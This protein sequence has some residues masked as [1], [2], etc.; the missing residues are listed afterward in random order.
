MLLW[1]TA[2]S[3]WPR[4]AEC[5]AQSKGGSEEM[6]DERIKKK[7]CKFFFSIRQWGRKL[8]PELHNLKSRTSSRRLSPALSDGDLPVTLWVLS[9]YASLALT[10]PKVR[11]S[12]PLKNPLKCFWTQSKILVLLPNWTICL[13]VW[14][15]NP[16]SDLEI[17]ADY[18][19]SCGQTKRPK[20]F[21]LSTTVN[22]KWYFGQTKHSIMHYKGHVSQNLWP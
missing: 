10:A 14:L 15:E 13:R 22:S 2:V 3:A 8:T 11:V 20:V 6:L 9:T 21:S 16:R 7:R 19:W 18:S 1:F 12:V 17:N 4:T 5:L